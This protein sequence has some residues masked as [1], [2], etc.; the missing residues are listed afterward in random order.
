[1]KAVVLG[2]THGMG[3]V[4]AR[5]L[6]AGGARVVVTGNHPVRAEAA[7]LELGPS[8]RVERSDIADL[9]Q[10][11]ELARLVR[12]HLQTIDAL[13]VFAGV[14]ELS[15]FDQVTAAS[16]ER[17]FG[18]NTRGAFFAVQRLAPLVRDGGSITLTTVTAAPASPTMSVYLASKAAVRAFAQGIAA[19][20]LPRRI[21]V[22]TVAPGFIDTPSLGIMDI[23]E[24]ERA[25]LRRVGDRVTPMKRHGT[26][27]EVARAA[28][29]LAFDATFTTGAELAVDGGL[30]QV[31]AA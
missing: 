13:L 12:E 15:P 2:G 1:M 29:F 17:Q 4:T 28:L 20:L 11:D 8:A 7:R 9:A 25:E 23:T 21:R 26:P 5:R 16:F 18:V 19:E 3:L 10:L 31:T 22:N 30:A 24:A 27:E 6:V 14:S